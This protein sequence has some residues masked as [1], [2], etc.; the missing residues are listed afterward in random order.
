[1]PAQQQAVSVVRHLNSMK[2]SSRLLWTTPFLLTAFFYIKLMLREEGC[3]GLIEILEAF[4]IFFTLL[5][6]G[7]IALL[8]SFRKRQTN[9]LKFEPI[10]LSL[11]IVGIMVILFFRLSDHNFKSKTV[12]YAK[13]EMKVFFRHNLTFRK[14]KTY[15]AQIVG[16]E[17]NCIFIGQYSISHDTIFLNNNISELSG[18]IFVEKYLHRDSKLIP[19]INSRDT[20]KNTITLVVEDK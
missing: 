17:A 3:G 14:D 16:Y 5:A 6:T 11:T 10:T 8:V 2:V 15:K 18:K 9:T 19:I 7:F 4:A 12:L 20:S 1:M 13:D